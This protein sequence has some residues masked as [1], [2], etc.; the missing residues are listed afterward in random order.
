MTPFLL[1]ATA[2]TGVAGYSGFVPVRN[3]TVELLLYQSDPFG[4]G[5]G[6]MT[7]PVSKSKLVT[8]SGRPGFFRLDDHYVSV[9]PIVF[10]RGRVYLEVESACRTPKPERVNEPYARQSRMVATGQ[11]FTVYLE[12]NSTRRQSWIEVRVK[13]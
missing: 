11:P 9:L 8:Q 6:R 12:A 2:V 4:R 1:A 13:P 7:E 3:I 10:P 5:E